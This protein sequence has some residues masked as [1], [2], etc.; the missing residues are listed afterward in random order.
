MK[1]LHIKKKIRIK[2]K[3]ELS[4]ERVNEL[5][6]NIRSFLSRTSNDSKPWEIQNI[7][8]PK[9]GLRN[10]NTIFKDFLIMDENFNSYFKNNEFFLEAYLYET[11]SSNLKEIIPKIKQL[12]ET[13]NFKDQLISVSFIQENPT[14]NNDKKLTD[15][16]VKTLDNIYGQGFLVKDYGQVPFFNDDFAYFQQ[17]VPG[18]YFL[19]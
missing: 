16:A 7:G 14:V 17:K 8:D 2:L 9:I 12:I 6:K 10:P 5:T 4:S 11:D 18:V 13:G 19:I 15:I 3:K 1:Y